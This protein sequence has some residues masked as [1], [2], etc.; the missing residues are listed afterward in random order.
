MPQAAA[1]EVTSRELPMQYREAQVVPA[2]FNEVDGT[3]DVVWTTGARIRRFDWWRGV[4]YEEELAVTPDAVNMS[5]FEAGSVQVLD[6]HSVYGGVRAIL[7]IA[8][9]G[10]IKS[11]EGLATLR[12]STDPA[13]AGVVGDVRA[14]IIRNISVGYSVDKYDITA[15]RD[16]K[17]G[18]KVDLYRAVLW[19]P[20]ELS[21]VPINADMDAGTRAQFEQQVR[22]Q[23]A[24]PCEFIRSTK[25]STM[26]EAELKAQQE[27]E[28]AE[29]RAAEEAAAQKRAADETAAEAE[30]AALLRAADVTTLC[31]RHGVPQMAADLIR[32]GK[33]AEQAGVAILDELARRDQASGG[34]RNVRVETVTDEVQTR[35]EGM[36]EALMHRVDTRTKLNE[37]GRQFRGMSLLE[38]GRDW[39]ES[40]GIS[41]RGMDK[42]TLAQRILHSRT[43]P[44]DFKFRD[45]PGMLSTSDFANV[46]ANV[47]NKRLR[48]GYEENPGT[49]SRWAR[50]APNAPDFKTITVTQLSALPDLLQVNEHGEFKY[51]SMSDGKETYSLI[52]YGRIVALTR[53]AIVNDDLRAFDRLITGFGASA[54]R[55]EN[56]TVYAILTANAALSDSVALFHATHANLASAGAGSALQLS[57]L[58]TA[59]TAMRVQKGLQSEELNI[60]PSTLIVPAALEQTAYQLTSNQYVPAQQS[61]IN[62]FRS[63]GKTALDPV[64]EPILDANSATVWYLAASNSQ[65]DTVEYCW[66]DGAEGPVLDTEIGFEVDGLQIKCREDFAAKALDYRGLYKSPGA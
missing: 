66:L 38:V 28:A 9:R 54:Q 40:R 36:A 2:S 60:A 32:A 45:S 46:L 35:M 26:T 1:R 14:G 56:R 3:V 42:M 63:G 11:G 34:Q 47:A 61:N 31:Q 20:G 52:T 18:G 30:K 43:L 39:L 64:I 55:L 17:D 12:L 57:S 24:S 19:T 6:S 21:F 41:T 16:R 4:E 23:G 25:E 44:E 62:E 49:Y 10:S 59:R 65:V 5:R 15:A 33:T 53:Q 8:I 50:R 27:K 13:K 51:G 22:S 29:K 7:G 58:T 37:N 48:M